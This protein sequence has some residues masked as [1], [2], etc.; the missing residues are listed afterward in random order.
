[1]RL[2][3]PILFLAACLAPPALAGVFPTRCVQEP[4]PL[5]DFLNYTLFVTVPTT[6]YHFAL[7]GT[8]VKKNVVR[9]AVHYRI[10]PGL[11]GDVIQTHRIKFTLLAPHFPTFYRAAFNGRKPCPPKVIL[12]PEPA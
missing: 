5:S 3:A 9:I 6:G 1:M 4:A 7:V 11:H 12:G 10:D 2:I 8:R